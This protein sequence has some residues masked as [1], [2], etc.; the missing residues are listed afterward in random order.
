MKFP[1]N[2][3]IKKGLR[4]IILAGVLAGIPASVLADVQVTGR[5]SDVGTGSNLPGARITVVDGTATAMTNGEGEYKLNVPSP[6]VT[7]YVEAPGFNPVRVALRGNSTLDIRLLASTGENPAGITTADNSVADL[8]GDL[9][10]ISRSGMPGTGHA[11]FVDGLHSINSSSQPL[12]VVDGVVWATADGLESSIVDGHFHNPLALIDPNDIESVK[13]LRNGTA[14]YGTKGG[15]GVVFITTKRAKDEA[16]KIEAWASVGFRDRIKSIPVMDASQYRLYVSDVIGGMSDKQ[17]FADGFEFLNDDPTSIH[18]KANH[19]NTDWLDLTTRGGVLMNYGVSVRGGD[20]R[21][22]YAFSLGYTKN[23]GSVKETSFERFNVRFNSDINLWKG[24]KLRFDIAFA[25]ATWHLFDDGINTISSPTYLAMVKSPLY[26]PN[27]I[28]NNGV[29]TQKYSDVDELNIGNPL[30][31]LDLGKA[32]NRNY[33]FNLAAN[34]EYKFNDTWKLGATIGYTFDKLKENNFTPDYGV[35]DRS[36]LN[37]NGEVYATSLNEVRTLMGRQTVF[38]VDGYADFH[39]L[40]DY[41]N[42]LGFR[43]GYRFRND[44]YSR[45]YGEG[46]NTPSDHVNAL[47]KTTS[48]LRF[49][50]GLDTKW[51]NIGWYVTG[52]YSLYNRYFLNVAASMETSSLFGKNASDALNIGGVAWGLFPS[53]NASWLISSERWMRN[54]TPINMMR[55]HVGYESAGNDRIPS[56]ANMTYL[57]SEKVAGHAFGLVLANIGNDKIKWETTNTFNVG[58]DMN[59]FSNRWMWQFSF[60]KSTTDDLLML[61]QLKEEAGIRTFWTNGGS[62]ENSGVNF[63]T[64][65]RV[66]DSREVK[67]DVGASIG[68]YRNKVKSLND[69][70][71]ITDIAGSQILT[72]VGEPIGVFYGYK[73]KGVF[74]TA[75]EAGSANLAI[76]NSDGSLSL[77]EAGDMY[78]HDL[79]ADGIIDSKDRQVIGDPNPDFYGNFNFR[80]SWKGFTLSTLFTF[81]SGNDV[82]NAL[83]ANLESGSDIYNQSTAMMNRWV[84]NGQKTDIPRATYGDPMGNSRFSDRWIEDGSYLKWKS[85]RLSYAIPLKTTAIQGVEVW[86]EMNNIKTWTKYLGQDPESFTG[87]NPLYLGVDTGLVPSVREYTFGVK[88]NI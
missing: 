18:Y 3:A 64:T 42:N 59:W 67:L 58:L 13:V 72:S 11:V 10:A 17:G 9:F 30:S 61:K 22:L 56:L 33:R 27:V 7:L 35:E 77:F 88:I 50:E 68:H 41:V 51:R 25:Q 47:G 53:V 1:Y 80:L 84:A 38:N 16:T 34:P 5:V 21:A 86:F 2:K 44:T 23:D 26:H 37:A 12:Y 43:L 81:S 65:V 40:R 24:F 87:Y 76:R 39:P 20:D 60:F 28:S 63:S 82:Y 57:S 75:S 48:E 79:D 85:L 49:S 73:T 74:S 62:L 19:N 14:L 32:D 70:S 83:R 78:F 46:H 55:L 36:L 71:F 52:D 29:V 69:G 8:Q 66:V 6:D 45:S 15:N 54:L 31:I 4:G